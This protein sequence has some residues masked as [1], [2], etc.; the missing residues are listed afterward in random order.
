LFRALR[1]LG[2]G[3]GLCGELSPHLGDD[4]YRKKEREEKMGE[5][6]EMRRREKKIEKGWSGKNR[7][8][9]R[10]KENRTSKITIFYHNVHLIRL[11]AHCT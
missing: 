3:L 6:D 5:R 8:R 9:N 7:R 1:G 11:A 2:R 4:S 10:S